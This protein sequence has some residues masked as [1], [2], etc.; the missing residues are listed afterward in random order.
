VAFDDIQRLRSIKTFPSL[1][2]YLRDELD[3]PIESDDTEELTFEYDPEELGIDPK[4]AAKIQEIKQLRPMDTQQPWG[5]F[6]VKFEPKHLPVVV[7][8]K[9]LNQLVIKK[10]VSSGKSTQ[11]AWKLHDLLFISSYGEHEERQITFAHFT[12][13]LAGK[14]LPTLRV[15]GWD[16][17]DTLL[18]ID[19]V[20]QTLKTNFRWPQNFNANEVRE[21]WSSA[22]AYRYREAVT[23][24][25]G[26]AERLAVL[27]SRIRDQVLEVMSYET[28]K[29]AV[30]QLYAAFRTGLIHD[31][32]PKDFA[33]MYAQTI[34]YGLLSARI[35]D[36][37]KTTLDDFA[38]HMRTN[39]FLREL[40]ETFLR[41]GGRKGKAGG[42]GIDF[43]ELGV[44]EVVALLDEANME[45]VVRDFGDRNPTDDPV[46]HFYEH[47]LAAYDKRLKVSRG[48]FYTPQPV[49]SYIVRSVHSLLRTE[50]GLEDG[51]ADTTTWGEMLV[52]HPN[53]K[54]PP[55]TN[56]PGEKRS[57]SPD[58]PF[59]QILDPATGTATFLVE[60]IE[61]I[62]QTLR[63]KW[64]QQRLT[65]PQLVVAWNDYVPQHLLPRLHAFE[66]MMAPYAIAHMKIGL[67][68][69]ETGYRFGTEERARIYLTNALEPWMKQ[70][71]LIGFDALAHEATAVNEVKKFKR[72]TVVIGN[73]PYSGL[74]A[75]M[76]EE[77]G[78]IIEPYKYLNG[79]HFGERKHW[80]HDDY[81]KFFRLSETRVNEAGAGV[82]GLITNHA[83]Y[84]NPTFNGMRWNLLQSFDHL[85][86]LDLHGNTM[87]RE[88]NPT[89]GEDKN[90]FDIQQGVAISLFSKLLNQTQRMVTHGEL[91]GTRDQK[92]AALSRAEVDAISS[93]P[94]T[95]SP[96]SYFFVPR[97]EEN[98]AEYE[99]SLRLNEIFEVFAGGFITARDHFVIDLD[100]TELLARI[101]AFADPVVSDAK[102][103]ETYFAGCGS[104][105]YPDGDTRGWKVPEA[106]RK[107]R[108]D[109]GWDKHVCQ[110]L[111]RPFDVRWIY[112]TEGMVD[113]TRPEANGHLLNKGNIALAFMRQA[114]T[115]DGYSH[116]LVSRLPVDNRA[117]YSNK[118][119]MTLAPLYLHEKEARRH[120]EL[121]FK[122]TGNRT[123][124]TPA[125]TTALRAKLGDATTTL[126]PEDIFYYAYAVFHSPS[127]RNRY[128]EFLK[129]DFPRLPLTANL[130]LF[131]A[132][133][134]IGGQITALHLMESPTLS[135]AGSKFIGSRNSEVEKI[136]WSRNTVWVNKAQTTGFHGVL[137]E[138]WNFQIG[139][140]QVCEKWLKDRKGRLLAED[141]IKEYQKIVIAISE[142]IRLMAEVDEVIERHGGW[143]GA[144]AK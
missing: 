131:H 56:E 113:W 66:L 77:A 128:A 43:D 45:A 124:F 106:R 76:S 48:V 30:R 103:R 54:L 111:Y 1:V 82:L 55:L 110:C 144:F 19:E 126:I 62:H 142:T 64:K 127:Y 86:L 123:N 98:A 70:P 109:T 3:W 10:R 13:D 12:Q 49:V 67:K 90:V 2:K 71:P 136:S 87:K 42:P 74:S 96:T 32:E 22:F 41:I 57:I 4:T 93:N 143:P 9:I 135:H 92:Y 141:D 65:E 114:A 72:F 120:A 33:D 5:I 134:K 28:E 94:L 122:G 97:M 101:K 108:A 95:P 36:P 119:I 53:L 68:L 8:R 99:N 59:V 138:V 15:L 60:V 16:G 129:T 139:G 20:V 75:N 112:W 35:A 6:F 31:L 63:A 17:R 83:F 51:L 25:S 132:L 104:D 88:R 39:P 24:A 29:G 121:L 27:A 37:T 84:D 46:I 38:A 73:P 140:Y 50:F 14:D 80:L 81:V 40:M 69:T 116:F 78:R 18:H 105:K 47:F 58:E 11:A 118:G 61:V 34:A 7:L 125:F 102:I 133:A 23:T 137:Q 85:R 21:R 52:K 44:S 117:C 91:W 89:G 100:R 115:G 26:L 79:V 130:D 107:I